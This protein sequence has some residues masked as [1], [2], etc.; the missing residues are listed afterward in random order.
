MGIVTSDG[1]SFEIPSPMIGAFLTGSVMGLTFE[2]E[3]ATAYSSLPL[4]NVTGDLTLVVDS[5]G[6]EDIWNNASMAN[7]PTNSNL[8]QTYNE[9]QALGKI[10]KVVVETHFTKVNAAPETFDGV[11][12][13][14][15]LVDKINTDTISDADALAEL[16]TPG[17]GTILDGLKT[18]LEDTAFDPIDVDDTDVFGYALVYASTDSEAGAFQVHNPESGSDEWV[19]MVFAETLG[20]LTFNDGSDGVRP[21]IDIMPVMTDLVS[22]GS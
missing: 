15:D 13:F 16:T 19:E 5:R 22:A 11:K 8:L 2:A 7:V 14:Y 1:D 18:A 6:N 3:D 4:I 9:A 17:T 12:A 21:I 20:N 10:A